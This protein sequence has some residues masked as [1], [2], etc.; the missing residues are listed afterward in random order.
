VVKSA[1]GVEHWHGASAEIG[2]THI[3][4]TPARSTGTKWLGKVTDAQY[5]AHAVVHSGQAE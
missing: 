4:I 1:P 3:A 2:A 5:G